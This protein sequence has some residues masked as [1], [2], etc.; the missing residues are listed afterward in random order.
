MSTF[1]TK[2]N[3]AICVL[4]WIHSYREINDKVSPCCHGSALAPGETLEHI[5]HEM[6]QGKKPSACNRCYRSEEKSKWS[7]RIQET[8]DW[9]KKH[10]E[11]DI[12][13]P[14]VQSID[15]R[16]DPTCNLK[17][18]TCGPT[19]S[20]LWKKEKNIPVTKN[21]FNLDSINQINKRKLRKVYIAGGEPTYINAYLE[22]LEDLFSVNPKCEVII[23]T[24]LKRLPTRWKEI[25]KKYE[26]IC[27]VCSCDAI[28]NL[29]TYVRYP[30][31]WG[32]FEKNVH[33]ASQHANF[34]QFNLVASNLTAHKLYETCSWM[35][36]YSDNINISVLQSPLIF[37]EKAV[38]ISTRQNYIENL[39]K[40]KKFPVS[41]YYA[42][43]FR[44][45]IN[46]L[47]KNYEENDYDQNLHTKLVE[48]IREQDSHRHLKLADV[49]PFLQSWI[50]M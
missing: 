41:I 36:Q 19:Y 7:P 46:Y 43:S 5:R 29:A 9:L 4:P 42:V 27:I 6:L 38:P 28:E 37:S 20:T 25:I 13:K 2:L 39:K 47:I 18:K 50:K 35:K 10:G 48:E 11:P 33:F 15:I 34:L 44:S 12:N 49:D 21:K 3:S 16:F 23:N 26:N 24:N 31:D 8:I 14:N 32:E 45:Q 1:D 17:C 22:W 40:L 30:I